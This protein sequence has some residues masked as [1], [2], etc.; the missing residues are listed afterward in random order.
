M[1][2]LFNVPISGMPPCILGL[3]RMLEKGGEFAIGIS[4]E[5]LALSRD[6]SDL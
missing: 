4:P 6:C 1:S 5:G 3:E 2:G